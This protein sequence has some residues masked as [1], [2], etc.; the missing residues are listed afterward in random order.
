MS[1][2][3]LLPDGGLHRDGAAARRSGPDCACRAGGGPVDLVRDVDGRGVPGRYERSPPGAME[4]VSDATPLWYAVQICTSRGSGSIPERPGGSSPAAPSPE[5]VSHSYCSGGNR[6]PRNR[7][8]GGV[9][10]RR[11]CGAAGPWNDP[12]ASRPGYRLAGY[13]PGGWHPALSAASRRQASAS[14]RVDRQIWV[15]NSVETIPRPIFLVF[16]ATEIRVPGTQRVRGYCQPQGCLVVPSVRRNQW[17][18]R[19]IARR[20]GGLARRWVVVMG[21]AS[22]PGPGDSCDGEQE[23]HLD[24]TPEDVVDPGLADH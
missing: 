24:D 3:S 5:G 12:A 9:P 23:H 11:M 6:R 7:L 1:S 20:C 13:R 18:C 14:S 8:Q 15:S 4:Y 16:L 22:W 10:T 2:R 21:W 17:S 19:P